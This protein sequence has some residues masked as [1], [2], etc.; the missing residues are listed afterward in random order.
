MTMTTQQIATSL[1][2]SATRIAKWAEQLPHLSHGDNAAF[3]EV[4]NREAQALMNLA[5]EIEH[6]K[7]LSISEEYEIQ[8]NRRRG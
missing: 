6:L 5:G 4:M 1:R 8:E 3:L 2:I 7:C